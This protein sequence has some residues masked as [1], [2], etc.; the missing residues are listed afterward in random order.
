MTTH[1]DVQLVVINCELADTCDLNML[2][3]VVLDAWDCY[4]ANY[5]TKIHFLPL[6]V[7]I[8]TLVIDWVEHEYL[9]VS[10]RECFFLSMVKRTETL[11]CF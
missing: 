2:K 11:Y 1:C 9:E 7:I 5:S 10:L 8:S 3:G 4:G 6:L